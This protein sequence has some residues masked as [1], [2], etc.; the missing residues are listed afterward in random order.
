MPP[1]TWM[2]SWAQCCAATGARVAAT[3]AA[4]SKALL[5]E[6]SSAR[7]VDGAGGVPHRGGGPLGVG[8]HL[9]ALVLDGLELADR[10]AELL[11]D[12]GVGRRGVGG[13]A[14]DADGLGGQQRRHQRPCA[15]A[16]QVA[17]HAVV[18]DLD[19]IG[20]HVRD[21]SQRVDAPHGLDLELVGVE[22]HPLLAAV[23][24]PPAAPAPT[25]GRP[26]GTARTSPRMTSASPWRVAV[27]PESM[28]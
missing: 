20:A 17:Q 16:A 1:C 7:L 18:A 25:P 2:Q 24:R 19:G 28:A 6:P 10:P 12:L 5:S 22:D 3:A 15:A 4:N 13:P 14:G 26:A 23:D 9:G 8:D 21:R 11:A 27:R